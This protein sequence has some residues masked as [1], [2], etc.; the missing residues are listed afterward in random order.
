[1]S[2]G[3]VLS[4]GARTPF[5]LDAWQSSFLW[6]AGKLAPR[7]MDLRDARDQR[8]GS[9]RARC[10]PDSLMGTQRLV[11]L[12]APALSEA[13]A[14]A[15]ARVAEPPAVLLAIAE[16]RPG[17][18]DAG[19]RGLL[20]EIA[21]QARVEIDLPRSQ[22][23][24]L[25]HAGFAVALQRATALLSASRGASV[26]VGGVDTYHHPATLAWL[27]AER[28]LHAD[29]VDNGIIPSEGA[30]FLVLGTGKR[31]VMA[32]VRSVACGVEEGSELGP[33]PDLARALIDVL[34]RSAEQAPTRPVPWVLTDGNGERH[35]TRRWSFASVRAPDIVSPETTQ[36]L[37][38]GDELGDMGAAIGAM[39]AVHAAVSFASGAVEHRAALIALSSE[40]P[41]RGAFVMEAPE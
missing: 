23:V 29:S 39:L 24:Q 4:V 7:P 10:L 27:D 18:E 33:N 41:E 12:A 11:A 14:G 31:E 32:H 15:A 6:R 17:L 8:I 37:E 25:G 1:M 5:G 30:A 28:R 36:L 13:V 21:H 9:M 3:S 34:R 2:V 35:R 40:G 16:P 19:G 22:L 26:V 20:S 38:A